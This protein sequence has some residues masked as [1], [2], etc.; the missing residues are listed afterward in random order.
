MDG[1]HGM[2]IR[3][4]RDD[5][6]DDLFDIWQRS[7]AAT[8]DFLTAQDLDEIA[9]T[10]LDQYLPNTEFLVITDDSD[11]PYGFMGMTNA[12]VDSLFID[13]DRRGGGAGRMLMDEAKRLYPAGLTVDVNEQNAQA[14]GFYERIGFRVTGRTPLDGMGKPY[15]IL[16]LQWP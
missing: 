15:P 7:V 2:P 9:A 8:H 5:E 4:S 3:T 12:N 11:R 10:V 6:T 1:Y 16:H 14:V 13:P